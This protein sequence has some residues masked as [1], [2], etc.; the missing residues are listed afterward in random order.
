[1]SGLLQGIALGM[2]TNWGSLKTFG[3]PYFRER[4][5]HSS[6]GRLRPPIPIPIPVAG[7]ASYESGAEEWHTD[8]A[9]R[10]SH[11]PGDWDFGIGYFNVTSREPILRPSPSGQVLSPHYGLMQQ[12]GVDLQYTRDAWLWK[13][14]GL[15]RDAASDRF[16]A[17]VGGFEYTV[18]QFGG[19]TADLGILAAH[20]PLSITTI[21][22][23]DPA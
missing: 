17:A 20:P 1:M 19:R 11:Y 8:F 9:L 4:T 13:F 10:Y 3:F 18:Y 15:A 21:S 12:F 14:E 23:S 7:S 5:F 22:F 16:L 6:G 2:Q